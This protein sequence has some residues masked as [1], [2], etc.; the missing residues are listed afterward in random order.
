MYECVCVWALKLFNFI[1]RIIWMSFH[2]WYLSNPHTFRY[3]TI[4]LTLSLSS[5]CLYVGLLSHQNEMPSQV[6]VCVCMRHVYVVWVRG[7][8]RLSLLFLVYIS[9]I[10]ANPNKFYMNRVL[11][12]ALLHTMSYQLQ[13]GLKWMKGNHMWFDSWDWLNII[14]IVK[15]G[16]ERIKCGRR[17]RKNKEGNVWVWE[18][19]ILYHWR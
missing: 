11:F 12:Q 1:H 5:D 2:F 7:L 3:K 16:F 14:C 15:F 9:L 4:F 17:K 18:L 8:N 6:C 19:I 10:L 13:N